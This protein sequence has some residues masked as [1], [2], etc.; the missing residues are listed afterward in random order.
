MLQQTA[1]K[2]SKLVEE[3]IVSG[4]I[5]HLSILT[6]VMLTNFLSRLLTI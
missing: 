4:L 5:I 6:R 2:G 1:Y 3:V